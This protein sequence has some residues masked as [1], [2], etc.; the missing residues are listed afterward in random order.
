[1]SRHSS[2]ADLRPFQPKAK[3]ESQ[4]ALERLYGRIAIQEVVE[5]LHHLKASEPAKGERAA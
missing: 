1:M 3:L 2:P 4:E 5:A